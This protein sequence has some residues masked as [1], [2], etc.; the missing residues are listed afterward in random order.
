MATRFRLTNTATNPATVPALQS[1]THNAPADPVRKLV[2]TDASAL[3][4]VAYTP[5]GA[6]HL[7][8]GDALH[9]QFV[10]DPIDAGVTFTNGDVIK[11]AVQALEAGAAN[12][13]AIQLWVGVYDSA[14][15]T[16]RR[17]LRT[18]VSEGTELATTLT[19]RFLSTT[20]DGASYTTVANDVLAVE[21]SVVGTP[22]ASGGTQGH[23]ASLRWG[24]DGAGGDLAENDTETGTTFNP[25]IE[26]VPAIFATNATATPSTVAGAATFGTVY[27]PPLPWVLALPTATSTSTSAVIT[28]PVAITTGELIYLRS[29]HGGVGT[30]PIDITG[31]SDSRGNTYTQHSQDL[32]FSGGGE[33]WS[34]PIT[35]ALQVNDTITITAT[36]PDSV[37]WFMVAH[38]LR[39]VDQTGSRAL[40]V[41]H[42]GSGGTTSISL[43]LTSSIGTLPYV[44]IGSVGID[45]GY[46]MYTEDSDTT[47][48]VAWSNLPTYFGSTADLFMQFKS[49]SSDVTQTYNTSWTNSRAANFAMI[50]FKLVQ[51]AAPTPATIAGTTTLPAPTVQATAEV[52]A[53]NIDATADIPQPAIQIVPANQFSRPDADFARDTWTTDAGGTT[54]LW[55]SINE[56][57]AS[58]ADYVK[59][60][61]DAVNDELIVTLANIEDPASSTGHVVRFRYRKS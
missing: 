19:N 48:G 41:T 23:N 12:N 53:E 15:T 31:I 57:S 34:A 20:Q 37:A 52:E 49:P 39:S 54:N 59:S 7:V 11:F 24:G 36:N 47:G 30:T 2:L 27:Q 56:T 10:S 18:K 8:A 3:T 42:T 29:K 17:A 35:T 45:S 43:D 4:T 21:F 14:G 46:G 28:V 38:Q 9:C 61:V 25:W 60:S 50:A 22:T 32:G 58:D 55:D 5:D 33:Q 1:Y 44:V 40:K 51:N 6:D 16:L 26:F 13:Q